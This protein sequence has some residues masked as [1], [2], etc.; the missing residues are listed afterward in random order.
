MTRVDFYILPDATADGRERL[1]CRLADKAYRLGHEVYI[2]ARDR[3]HA[4]RLDELLWTFRAGSFVPHQRVDEGHDTHE[5]PVL[6]GHAEA[7]MQCHTLLI[8]L[9]D[10][11][12]GF[13]S[14]FERVMETVD[15]DEENRRSGRERFRFYRDRGYALKTHTLNVHTED[16]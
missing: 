5:A 7:P 11:V 8:N 13:F 14:R 10:G 9:A 4:A 1:A 12:P 6:I 16:E 2:H 15:Q 3:Q